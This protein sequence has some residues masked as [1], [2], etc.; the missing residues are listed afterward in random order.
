MCDSLVTPFEGIV[1][2][3]MMV[4]LSEENVAESK[5]EESLNW[6]VWMRCPVVVHHTHASM[7]SNVVTILSPLGEHAVVV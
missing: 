5:D 7:L 3:V 1:A 4:M 6:S 2:V